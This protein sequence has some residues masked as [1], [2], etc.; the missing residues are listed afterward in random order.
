MRLLPQRSRLLATSEPLYDEVPWV[1]PSEV[2]PPWWRR[3]LSAVGLVALVAVL[4]VLFAAA[5][6]IVMVG[7]FFL[8]DY[9]IS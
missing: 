4:G 7:G 6:G 9:L 2:A 3:L 8:M 5:I 1:E